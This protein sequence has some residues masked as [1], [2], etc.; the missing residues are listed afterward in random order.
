MKLDQKDRC[1]ENSGNCP[2]LLLQRHAMTRVLIVERDPM[3]DLPPRTSCIREVLES[4]GYMVTALQSTCE[5]I[6]FL[7]GSGDRVDV[8]ALAMLQRVSRLRSVDLVKEMCRIPE[9]REIGKILVFPTMADRGEYVQMYGAQGYASFE[10]Q[11]YRTLAVN[12]QNLHALNDAIA[13]LQGDG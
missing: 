4:A 11:L 6:P 3:L 5:V 12:E 10:P 1:P 7:R 13:A 2:V 8:V 9:F